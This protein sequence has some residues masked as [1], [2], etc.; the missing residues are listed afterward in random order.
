MN[1]S[2]QKETRPQDKF[3]NIKNLNTEEKTIIQH[4]YPELI[5]NQSE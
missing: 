3:M 4:W 1:P 5:K 2:N